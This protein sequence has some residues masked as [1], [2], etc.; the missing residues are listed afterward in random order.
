LALACLAAQKAIGKK[1][2]D[3]GE[4]RA[5]VNTVVSEGVRARVSNK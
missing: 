2:E 5:S 4:V 3:S 1:N